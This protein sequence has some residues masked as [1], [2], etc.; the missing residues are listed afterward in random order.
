MSLVAGDVGSNDSGRSYTA[1][2]YGANGASYVV[3]GARIGRID[4]SAA[5]V[6]S[7]DDTGIVLC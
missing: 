1:L 3:N 2:L 5:L 7:C 4:V 6:R